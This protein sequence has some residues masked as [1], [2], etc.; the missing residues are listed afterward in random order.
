M[1]RKGNFWD[2]ASMESFFGTLKMELVHHQK[3]RTRQ[4]A[5]AEIS[6]Y[7]EI[8]YNRKRRHGCLGNL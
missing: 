4:E 3:Y 2:N 8:F 6:E 5:I 7:I 1:S